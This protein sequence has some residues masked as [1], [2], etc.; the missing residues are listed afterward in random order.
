MST[1]ETEIKKLLEN[2][3][4]PYLGKDLV[5]SGALKNIH[6]HDQGATVEIELGFPVETRVPM[7]W[8]ECRQH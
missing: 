3:I 4:D 1:T 7:C 8:T 5:S 2:E 6:M